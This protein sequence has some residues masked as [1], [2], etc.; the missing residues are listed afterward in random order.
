MI[1]LLVNEHPGH[2]SLCLLFKERYD[3][4]KSFQEGYAP[5]SGIVPVCQTRVL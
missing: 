1:Y 5:S 4:Y 3:L 2:A